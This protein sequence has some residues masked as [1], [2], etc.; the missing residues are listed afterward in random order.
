M[1]QI[2]LVLTFL[3][4]I[5]GVS[6]SQRTVYFSKDSTERSAKKQKRSTERNIIKIAPLSFISGYIPVYFEREIT[7]FFSL[8]GGIGVTTRNYLREWANNFEFNKSN[9]GTNVFPGT[10]GNYDNYNSQTDFTNRKS[11]LGYYFS[12]QPRIY[13]NNEGL[14]GGFFGLSYDRSRYNSSSKRIVTGSGNSGEPVFSNDYFKENETISDINASFG[15]QTLYDRIAV[16]YTFGIAIRKV[17]GRKYAYTNDYNNSGGFIEGYTD[18]KK[19][20]P[21]FTFSL[22][23]GYHY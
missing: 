15:G 22:K 17:T 5:S 19:T 21:A 14:D 7:P 9:D 8:Q 13:F 6:L 11:Q 1:R 2:V 3:I 16:E 23:I 4:A 12:V 10:T 20:I 18:L